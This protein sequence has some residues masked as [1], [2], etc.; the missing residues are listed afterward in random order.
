MT[1]TTPEQYDVL[2]VAFLAYFNR[3][4]DYFECHEVMEQLWLECGRDALY[5]GLLQVAVG[6]YHHRNGN[7]E[8][9]IKLLDAA[10]R[11]LEGH[12]PV[13]L[14]IDLEQL[15]DAAK[16]R[17]AELERYTAQPVPFRDLDIRIVDPALDAL[18]AAFAPGDEHGNE[19]GPE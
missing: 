19:D 11:K 15:L 14:G 8:G 17:L 1:E 6:L 9:G 2:Y 4:R 12:R 18:V 5:Q 3:E 7:M 13:V 16:R 10:I